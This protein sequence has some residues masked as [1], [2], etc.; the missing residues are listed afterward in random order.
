MYYV[1]TDDFNNISYVSRIIKTE[2]PIIDAVIFTLHGDYWAF[3]K[4][5]YAGTIFTAR[6]NNSRY[7]LNWET[8][9]E[10]FIFNTRY[11]EGPFILKRKDD[12][13]LYVD[14]YKHQK[15]YVAKFTDLG[16]KNDLT[17]LDD[18]MYSMPESDVRHA[19]VIE[20]TQIELQR[21]ID[22]YDK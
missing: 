1:T 7:D 17:W 21:L 15:F 6:S 12:Y 2:Y 5:N 18:S 16:E 11:I 9:D 3:Y 14:N 20:I 19:S 13:L 10:E 22:F 4:D 8:Y